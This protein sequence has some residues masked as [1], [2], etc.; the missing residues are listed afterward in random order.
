[1]TTSRLPLLPHFPYTTLFRSL[2]LPHKDYRRARA[3]A[4]N[5]IPTTTGAA[6]MVGQV[7]PELAGKLNGMAIRVPVSDGSLVDLVVELDTKVTKEKVNQV[8]KEAAEG[9]LKNILN[10]SEAPLVSTDII[11]NTNSE[12][13]DGL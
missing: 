6:K 5:I 2:D 7:I 13:I 9:S 11:G 4:E 1:P 3:A 10:Y 8:L 12:I